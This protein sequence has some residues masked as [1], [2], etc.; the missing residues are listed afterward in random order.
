MPSLDEVLE[1]FP[2]RSFLIHIKSNNPQ[3]GEILAQ[4]LG[5]MARM[6]E[7]YARLLRGWPHRFV[8]RMKNANSLFILTAGEGNWPG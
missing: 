3:E 5:N 4:Y 8:E 6:P 2:D 1:H 7:K